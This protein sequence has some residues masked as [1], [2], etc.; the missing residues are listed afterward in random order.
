MI[1]TSISIRLFGIV[2]KGIP[3]VKDV[4]NSN[5]FQKWKL[6]ANLVKFIDKTKKIKE[7]YKFI[8]YV[9]F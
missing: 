4:P 3:M 7:K 1:D 8:M 2:F 6:I 9:V 5:Y